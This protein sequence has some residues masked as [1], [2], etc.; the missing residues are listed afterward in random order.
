METM[1]MPMQNPEER[2]LQQLLAVAVEAAAPMTFTPNCHGIIVDK[3]REGIAARWE[4]P[5]APSPERRMRVA[6]ENLR[7]FVAEMKAEARKL[8]REDLGEN[9]FAGA[10]SRL[11]PL[12]PIC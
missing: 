4:A 2:V 5:G 3:I 9:T 10:W 1:P 11:C 12:W 7:K 6:E 8:G